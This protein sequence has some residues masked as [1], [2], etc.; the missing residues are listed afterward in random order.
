MLLLWIF[1]G[2]SYYVKCDFSSFNGI[3]DQ[4][5]PV[6]FVFTNHIRSKDLNKMYRALWDLEARRG[7][8]DKSVH[9]LRSAERPD[10][11]E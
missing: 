7:Y 9:E 4:W 11:S 6:A 3:F 10:V 2:Y 8:K 5:K 1:F